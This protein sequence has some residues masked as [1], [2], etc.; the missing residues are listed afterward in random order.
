MLP[1]IR[2]FF[3]SIDTASLTVRHFDGF[4]FLCGG[5]VASATDNPASVRDFVYRSILDREKELS[6][7]VYQAEDVNEW[8]GEDGYSD[9]IS[10]E[11]DVAHLADSIVIFVESPGSIAELGAFCQVEDIR[12]KLLVFV[13]RRH[14]ENESFIKRGPIRVIENIDEDSV[15]NYPWEYRVD[16]NGVSIL[17]LTTVEPH[18]DEFLEDI[19]SHLQARNHERV[20]NPGNPRHLMLL[21]SDLVDEFLAVQLRE[22]NELLDQFGAGQDEKRLKQLLFILENFGFIET[23]AYGRNKFKVARRPGPFINYKF[24]DEPVISRDRAR[25]QAKLLNDYKVTDKHRYRAIRS[26]MRSAE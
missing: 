2:P 8:Y 9:L 10:F 5:F 17:D 20:F 14:L 4:V 3:Q 25:R 24:V 23:S 1:S 6:E 16:E 12:R 26:A 22:L 18:R 13:Q 7:R 21:I 19:K 15:S 11:N